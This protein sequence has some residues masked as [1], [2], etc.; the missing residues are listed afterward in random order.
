[1]HWGKINKVNEL[2]CLQTHVWGTH[3]KIQKSNL[4]VQVKKINLTK[5]QFKPKPRHSVWLFRCDYCEFLIR[6]LILQTKLHPCGQV[7]K[8]L[9]VWCRATLHTKESGTQVSGSGCNQMV[10]IHWGRRTQTCWSQFN[11]GGCIF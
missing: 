9:T 1:M 11:F 5:S 3:G 4:Y 6:P 2:W 7:C 8:G 10:P